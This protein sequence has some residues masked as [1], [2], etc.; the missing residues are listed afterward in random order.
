V[1]EVLLQDGVS[2]FHINDLPKVDSSQFKKLCYAFA[3]YQGGK[4]ASF[5]KPH[6]PQNFF[7]AE[8]KWNEES[9]FI[10]LNS[11][12]PIVAFASSVD[13]FNI[14]FID[15]PP[16]IGLEAFSPSFTIAT[17]NELN[18]TL[19]VDEKALTVLNLN[20]LNP[21]EIG[22]IF[23]WKPKTVGDVVFNFWD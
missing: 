2:G 17:A 20:N 14:Q 7:K 13:Y 5:E 10:L 9:V 3:S 22:Q 12:Y 15:Q 16:L 19:K 6:E 23:Y 21:I 18:E 8:L 4:L 11:T 1:I